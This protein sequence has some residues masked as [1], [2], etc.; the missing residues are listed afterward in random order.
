M[1]TPDGH[2]ASFHSPAGRLRQEHDLIFERARLGIVCSH[3]RIILRCNPQFGEL[4]GYEAAAAVGQSTR[5]YYQSDAS[6]EDIGQRAYFAIQQHGV[7]DSE[8]CYQRSDGSLIWCHVT[9]CMLDPTEPEGGFVW[10]YEDI[11]L[12]RETKSALD[13]SLREQELIFDN[14]QIGISYL[15]NRVILR[16]N[17]R[18]EEIFGHLPGSLIGQTT[19]VLFSSDEEW[20]AAGMHYMTSE[21]LP[22]DN[23][24]GVVRYRRCDGTPIWVHAVGRTIDEP[25][26]GKTWIWT[27]EDVTAQKLAEE[28]LR[29]S[30]ALL[31]QR[32]AER[33]SELRGQLLFL[34]QLIDAIPGPIYYKNAQGQYLGCNQA[35]SEFVGSPPEALIGRSASHI[36]PTELLDQYLE[37]DRRLLEC[38]GAQIYENVVRHADGSARAVAFHKATFS[39][40]NGGVGGIVGFMLDISE[41]KELEGRLRQAAIVFDCSAEGVMITDPQCCIVAVNRA[42]ID[43]TGFC[44]EEVLGRNPGFLGSGQHDPVFFVRMWERIS[45]YGRWQGEIWNRRK[46]GQSFPCALTISVVRDAF[47][48]VTQYVGVFSDITQIKHANEQLN[49]LANHDPLTGLLNRRMLDTH[50]I[51]AL[52]RAHRNNAS[53]AFLFIDLD[54]FKTIN[55]SLGHQIGDTVLLEVAGRLKQHM[56]AS[57]TITRLGGDEFLI[58]VE[59]LLNPAGASLVAEKILYD[60]RVNPVLPEDGVYVGASVGISLYPKDGSD[61]QTLLRHADIAMYRAKEKGR[62][63]YSFF[64]RELCESSKDRFQLE[65]DLRFALQHGELRVFLQPKFSLRTSALV[66]AEALVRWQHPHRGLVPP[67]QFIPLAEE[68]G[69][70]VDIGEWVLRTAAH[71][72]MQWARRKLRPGV[73]SVNVS[74]I[75]FRRGLLEATVRDVLNSTGLAPDVLEL[76]ITESVVMSYAENCIASLNSLRAMGVG[77]AIDDFGTGYSSLAHLKRLPVGKLK[78]DRSFVRALPDDADDLAIVRTILALGR[79]LRLE[80]IAEGVETDAQLNLLRNEGCDEVQGFLTG[81]PMPPEEFAAYYLERTKSIASAIADSNAGAAG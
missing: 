3:N 6:W 80:V 44:E 72:W 61:P 35:F 33:T 21:S 49:Y 70:I 53:V 51:G 31:E 77:L 69:L 28:E 37:A 32:V 56:R 57:D 43:I 29:R 25:G 54:R 14:A 59:G 30:N 76:E 12:R 5:I 10:F 38:A 46:D 79:S 9:G 65:T 23:Y 16:C 26:R 17:R 45:E 4:F 40:A 67:D 71:C 64:S 68:S 63:T 41:R 42:F 62:N 50:L 20:E 18:F 7:F 19:R 27:H 60:L 75:E 47:G 78:I 36:A 11:T 39:D 2:Q 1:K 66:G 52:Q 73:L 74:G 55:D 24:E 8:E 58:V 81:K 15:C 48:K 13:R 34:Q 22:A